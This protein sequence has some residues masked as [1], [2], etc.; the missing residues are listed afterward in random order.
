[1]TLGGISAYKDSGKSTALAFLPLNPAAMVSATA[2]SFPAFDHAPGGGQLFDSVAFH[3]IANLTANLAVA[4]DK[5]V[6]TVNVQESVDGTVWTNADAAH[7][8]Q[9][10]LTIGGVVGSPAVALGK[11]DYRFDLSVSGLKKF[12]RL[13]VT[14]VLTGTA[15]GSLEVIGVVGPAR[16]MPINPVAYVGNDS[17]L[18]SNGANYFKPG[19]NC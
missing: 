3:I 19:Y 16:K 10:P 1:M 11:H 6:L 4:L 17:V 7:Q 13:Q 12:V 8:P 5:L 9:A 2:Q 18:G 15:A 14:P